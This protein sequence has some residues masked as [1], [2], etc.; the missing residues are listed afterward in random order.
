MEEEE[1]EEKKENQKQAQ[2]KLISS[3]KNNFTIR[4]WTK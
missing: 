1:V 2:R 3:I 4:K